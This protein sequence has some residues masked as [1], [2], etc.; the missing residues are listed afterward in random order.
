MRVARRSSTSLAAARVATHA[1]DG[2]QRRKRSSALGRASPIGA[3]HRSGFERA[4]AIAALP[5]QALRGGDARHPVSTPC[6]LKQCYG[7]A[8][9]GGVVGFAV[10]PRTP[11]DAYP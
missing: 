10:Y 11:D 4:V 5:T 1:R 6:V 7:G 3:V 2:S 8:V 9:L